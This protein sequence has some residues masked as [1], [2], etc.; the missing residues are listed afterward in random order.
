[1]YL[2]PNVLRG[3]I[4]VLCFL[5]RVDEEGYFI[6]VGCSLKRWCELYERLRD[7]DGMRRMSKLRTL[8][9]E[10]E[11]DVKEDDGK[12]NNADEDDAKEDDAVERRVVYDRVAAWLEWLGEEEDRTR[13]KFTGL[14]RL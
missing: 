5:S 6:W 14:E 2:V 10:K 7:K 9:K 1:M 4:S 3:K 13:R 8:E 11:A 12:E